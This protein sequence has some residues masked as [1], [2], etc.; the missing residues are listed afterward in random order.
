MFTGDTVTLDGSGSGDADG[1]ALTFKWSFTYLPPGSAATIANADSGIASFVPDVEGTYVV[2]LVVK[3]RETASVPGTRVVTVASTPLEC[4]LT[5]QPTEGD[6]PLTVQFT[7]TATGVQPSHAYSAPGAFTVTLKVE[8]G[9]GGSGSATTTAGVS[10]P[11]RRL[12]P[13]DRENRER[14]EGRVPV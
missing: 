2:Q 3:D 8:D 13:P 1:D 5:A 9:R 10:A 12:Q 11:L 7:G 14:Q 4:A 6:A